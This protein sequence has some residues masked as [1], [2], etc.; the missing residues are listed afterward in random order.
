MHSVF[1][2]YC[3]CTRDPRSR[4]ARNEGIV[5]KYWLPQGTIHVACLLLNL[6][7]ALSLLLP[8]FVQ[9]HDV[10][11]QLAIDRPLL[12]YCNFCTFV[13]SKYVFTTYKSSFLVLRVVNLH[14][15]H[16]MVTGQQRSASASVYGM[17][18]LLLL[19]FTEE[20]KRYYKVEWN[21]EFSLLNL[22]Q[23]RILVFSLGSLLP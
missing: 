13:Q 16:W 1:K 5:S 23:F 3:Q 20:G 21:R 10:S 7:G 9:Y 15:K 11:L 17:A 12:L 6:L 22:F 18:I 4:W 2:L 14:K 19:D 8:L